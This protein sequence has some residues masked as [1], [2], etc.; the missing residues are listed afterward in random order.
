MLKGAF[1]VGAYGGIVDSPGDASLA[2]LF[3]CGGKR[4]GN[5]K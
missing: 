3:A 5:K 1:F 4:W 2:H